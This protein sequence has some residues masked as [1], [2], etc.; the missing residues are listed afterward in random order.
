MGENA[1]ASPNLTEEEED[2]I[3]CPDDAVSIVSNGRCP[4]RLVVFNV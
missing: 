1:P 4:V 2:C 3:I